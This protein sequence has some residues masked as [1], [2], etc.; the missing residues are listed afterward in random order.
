MKIRD[1]VIGLRLEAAQ[2]LN[3]Q[4]LDPSKGLLFNRTP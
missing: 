3:L 1:R 4:A 2:P